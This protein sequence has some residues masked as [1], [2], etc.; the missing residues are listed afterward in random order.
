MCIILCLYNLLFK[1][2]LN[3]IIQLQFAKC[4]FVA[5]LQTIVTLQFYFI[6]KMYFIQFQFALCEHK[7]Y[8]IHHPDAIWINICVSSRQNSMYIF[9]G[10]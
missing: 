10:L 5:C 6:I 7:S 2:I 8:S 9:S 3:S 4:L 1:S